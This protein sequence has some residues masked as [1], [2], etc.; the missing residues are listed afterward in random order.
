MFDL[1]LFERPPF[2]QL[3]NSMPDLKIVGSDQFVIQKLQKSS[4]LS[5]RN[6]AAV[7]KN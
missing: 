4:Y 7:V 5:G 3:I 2:E 6:H 1:A